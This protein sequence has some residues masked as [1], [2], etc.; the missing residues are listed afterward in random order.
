M[1]KS[2]NAI[3]LMIICGAFSIV[4]A[5]PVAAG[6]LNVAVP[7][8]AGFG[9]LAQEARHYNAPPG[10]QC[11]KWTRRYHP[12]LGFGHKRCVHWK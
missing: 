11:I 5:A 10:K 7:P 6:P 4:A 8:D 2:T 3:S 9:S 12:S 1:R